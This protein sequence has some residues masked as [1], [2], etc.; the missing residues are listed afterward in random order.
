MSNYYVKVS[1]SKP[2]EGVYTWAYV[3]GPFAEEFEALWEQK[4]HRTENKNSHASFDIELLDWALGL[5]RF[6]SNDSEGKPV[7][8]P[9]EA[10]DWYPTEEKAKYYA[11]RTA[12]ENPGDV[13]EVLYCPDFRIWPPQ[14]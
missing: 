3:S 9:I 5:K 11:T 1:Y 7:Y 14:G 8:A 12:V 10:I 2:F 4:R 13:I 6:Q